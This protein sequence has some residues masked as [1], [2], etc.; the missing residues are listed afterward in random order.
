MCSHVCTCVQS[1]TTRVEQVGVVWRK[2]EEEMQRYVHVYMCHVRLH[3]MSD[4][5]DERLTHEG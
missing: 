3:C 2:L 5:R 4:A 1:I